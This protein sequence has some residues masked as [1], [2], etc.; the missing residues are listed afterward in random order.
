MYFLSII[1]PG[2]IHFVLE[3]R[4][5]T[6]TY[7]SGFPMLRV[8][9]FPSLKNLQVTQVALFLPGLRA[10]QEFPIPFIRERI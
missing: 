3:F 10:M 5:N 2:R 4:A 7:T 6:R 9:V 1:M 8:P